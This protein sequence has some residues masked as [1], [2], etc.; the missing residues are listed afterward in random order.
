MQLA[1]AFRSEQQ[2][3]EFVLSSQTHAQWVLNRSLKIASSKNGL[4]PRLVD[5]RFLGFGLMFAPMPRLKIAFRLRG[6]S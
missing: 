6:Q 1:E 4:R 2:M 3:A 5:C